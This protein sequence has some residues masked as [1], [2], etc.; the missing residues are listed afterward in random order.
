MKACWFPDSKAGILWIIAISLYVSVNSEFI[1]FQSTNVGVL[2]CS[3]LGSL[4]EV[5]I[6]FP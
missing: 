3:S 2:A 4:A 1:C 5:L 6:I